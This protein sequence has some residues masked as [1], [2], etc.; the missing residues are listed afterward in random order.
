M[1]TGTLKAARRPQEDGTC[2]PEQAE[3][4]AEFLS[5]LD[6]AGATKEALND[7]EDRL[8]ERI[9]QAETRL[10]ERIDRFD[11]HIDRAADECQSIKERLTD[12]FEVRI[13]K[14]E[15]RLPVGH[16]PAVAA[17]AALLNDLIG[18]RCR[19]A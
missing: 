4:I 7:L 17:I 18:P 8:T 12:R 2:S 19:T 1:P 11:E 13:A 15:R 5:D 14:L 16:A 3:R 9:D 10:G 6:V